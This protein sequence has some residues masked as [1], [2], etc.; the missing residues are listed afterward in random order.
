MEM[1]YN[2]VA[3]IG[4]AALGV[5]LAAASEP[6]SGDLDLARRLASGD[7]YVQQA[8]VGQIVKAGAERVPLLLS[9]ARKP[10]DGV[11][12]YRLN[13]GLA[14]AFGQMKTEASVP[15]LIKV[16]GINRFYPEDINPWIKVPS[17]IEDA[18]PAAAALIRIGPAGAKAAIAAS[19]G[20]MTADERLVAIFV[21]ARV[22]GVGPRAR[23]FLS[24]ARGEA[25]LELY[26]AEEGLKALEL[27]H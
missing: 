26:W 4:I 6:D 9:W 2:V 17:V 13:I 11:D 18:Y 21:V 10:P 24:V 3:V 1:A 5:G 15:F 16:I 19:D 25:N 20:P 14:D 22:R 7:G 23:E 12:A 8:T 27:R